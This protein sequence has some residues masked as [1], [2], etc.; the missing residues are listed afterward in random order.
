MVEA[1][2]SLVQICNKLFQIMAGNEVASGGAKMMEERLLFEEHDEWPHIYL[3]SND[4]SHLYMLMASTC[5][6]KK[7]ILSAIRKI[8]GH[9]LARDTVTDSPGPEWRS[10]DYLVFECI[11]DGVVLKT[12]PSGFGETNSVFGEHLVIYDDCP[13]RSEILTAIR[14]I[15]KDLLLD[16]DDDP[17]APGEDRERAQVLSEP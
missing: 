2:K 12:V 7:S 10:T 4:G 8:L 15:V 13:R 1:T 6:R 5:V 17:D 9:Q 16:P 14:D 3:Y 11:Y